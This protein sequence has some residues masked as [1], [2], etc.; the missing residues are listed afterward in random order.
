MEDGSTED[1]EAWGIPFCKTRVPLCTNMLNKLA[2]YGKSPAGARICE[3][4][5]HLCVSLEKL[6]CYV[7]TAH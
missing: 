2:Q 5:T 4:F 6:S 1:R 3:R 7:P